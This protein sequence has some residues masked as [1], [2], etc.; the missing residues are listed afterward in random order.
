MI[1]I[2]EINQ[3]ILDDLNLFYLKQSTKAAH[4]RGILDP[5]PVKKLG[6][7]SGQYTWIRIRTMLRS[8]YVLGIDALAKFVLSVGR[9]RSGL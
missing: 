3:N 4:I 8:T 9:S 6:S 1:K 7:G 2:V 5:D